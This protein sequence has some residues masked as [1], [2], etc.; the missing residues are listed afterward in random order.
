LISWVFVTD[1]CGKCKG[2]LIANLQYEMV[3]KPDDSSVQPRWNGGYIKL[4]DCRR[5]LGKNVGAY[6]CSLVGGIVRLLHIRL[7]HGT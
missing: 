1:K 6:S 5:R 3:S 4:D 7:R 2:K